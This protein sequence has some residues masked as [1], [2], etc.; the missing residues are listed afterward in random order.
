MLQ[1]MCE[2]HCASFKS[3]TSEKL[4]MD[5]FQLEGTEPTAFFDFH[6]QQTL[7]KRKI[8]TVPMYKLD[9]TKYKK[10]ALVVTLFQKN[11]C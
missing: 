11:C 3:C 10:E 6:R 7:I 5:T 1:K 8:I 2:T 4:G 9:L